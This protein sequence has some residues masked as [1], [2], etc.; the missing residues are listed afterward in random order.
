MITNCRRREWVGQ[1]VR[2]GVVKILGKETSGI[3]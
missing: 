3:A 2:T 1:V